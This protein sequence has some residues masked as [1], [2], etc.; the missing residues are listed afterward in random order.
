MSCKR[1]D[2]SFSLL[3]SRRSYKRLFLHS[4]PAQIYEFLIAEANN[5]RMSV[6]FKQTS[7]L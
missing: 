7:I 5:E 3:F 2:V 1:G 4:I 6:P